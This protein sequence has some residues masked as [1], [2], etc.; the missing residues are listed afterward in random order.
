M[1]IPMKLIILD[2]NSTD[3]ITLR[4]LLKIVSPDI[5]I[6]GEADNIAQAINLIDRHRPD[7]IFSEILLA[8]GTA[9]Q[10]FDTLRQSNIPIGSLIC[11]TNMET[12]EAAITAI[13]YACLAFL[14]KKHLSQNSLSHALE[15]VKDRHKHHLGVESLLNQQPKKQNKIVIPVAHNGREIVDID[16]IN[17][18][19][20]IGQCTIVHLVNGSQITAFRI[21]GY[22]KKQLTPDYNF[23]LIHHSLLVN[24]EQVKSFHL[25]KHK[26]TMKNNISLEASRRQGSSFKEYWREFMSHPKSA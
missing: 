6:C 23:F 22:F 1:R 26:V 7:I 10:V 5:E 25:V 13:E 14:S 2:P 18:F 16:S 19:E 4:H 24:V 15:K 9:F 21:L 8:D 11:T 12:Y 3:I 17:H 20:A